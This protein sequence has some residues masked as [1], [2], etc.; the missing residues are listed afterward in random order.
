MPSTYAHFKFANQVPENLPPQLQEIIENNKTLYLIGCHGPDILFYYKAIKRNAINDQ[1]YAMHNQKALPFFEHAKKVIEN[2]SDKY[3]SLSYIMG[4]ITHFALDS[5]CH[6]YVEEKRRTG[7][8][9]HTKIEVEFDRALLIADGKDPLRQKLAEHIRAESEYASIIAPFFGLD[10]RI[11]KK[12]LKDMKFICN[13]FVAPG[14]I[15][16]GL[17]NGIFSAMGANELKDQIVGYEPYPP[18]SDSTEILTEKMK[19]ALPVALELIQ[20]YADAENGQ[21]LSQ[22]FNATYE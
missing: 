8:A 11:I 5:E 2:S 3:A 1:G 20:S 10:A 18:C 14:K 6:G 12:T 19:G 9:S 13:L 15:K 7:A 22:R 21:S 17:L 4:F 16:R